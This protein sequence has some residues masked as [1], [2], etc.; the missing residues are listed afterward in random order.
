MAKKA[1]SKKSNVIVE[2]P[3]AETKPTT[4]LHTLFEWNRKKTQ[5]CPTQK[6]YP[7]GGVRAQ[8]EWDK[9]QTKTCLIEE[10]YENGE[11]KSR[12]EW[13]SDH[14]DT[15]LVEYHELIED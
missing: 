14:S 7:D 10:Y 9:K 12:Y 6:F 11:L 8:Y 2:E 13:N 5:T 3:V 1:S 4:F 15:D